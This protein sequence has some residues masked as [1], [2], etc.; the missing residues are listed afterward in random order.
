MPDHVIDTVSFD[1]DNTLCRYDRSPGEV[2]DRAFED[3]GVPPL[4]SVEDYVDVFDEIA[5]TSPDMATLR[6]RAFETLATAAGGSVDDG[7]AV[8][9]AYTSRRDPTGVDWREGMDD[10]FDAIRAEYDD[11]VIVTNGMAEPQSAK[12]ESLGIDDRVDTV[13][14]ADGELQRKPAPDPF[15]A[16]LDAVGTRPTAA[17][18][19]GDSLEQDVAG[20]NAA[21][22]TSVWFPDPQW[23]DETTDRSTISPDIHV[24]S[25]RELGEVPW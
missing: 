24:T 3:A 11:V 15:V 9:D 13:V 5:E 4:F 10:V 21:G 18:H 22:L 6:R 16:A 19:I 17:V 2:L 23:V 8:A 20:A 12:L 25:A 1:L 7:R 14:F